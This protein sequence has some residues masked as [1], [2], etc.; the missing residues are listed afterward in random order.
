VLFCAQGSAGVK[1]FGCGGKDL[2]RIGNERDAAT[3]KNK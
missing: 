1:M 2:W 3:N